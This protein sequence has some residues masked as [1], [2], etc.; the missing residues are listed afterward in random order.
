MFLLYAEKNKITIKEKEIVT[1]G[2]ANIYDVQF[3]FDDDWEGLERVAVFRVGSTSVSIALTEENQ[4]LLPWECMQR[5]D[6]GK[7]IS[8]GVYGQFGDDVVLPTVWATLGVIKRS[9][10]L[11]DDALPKTPTL[12]EQLLAQIVSEREAA[13]QAAESAAKEA[14]KEV[15]KETEGLIEEHV[16]GIVDAYLEENP[17]TGGTIN[18]IP[19]GGKAG[20]I[21]KKASDKDFDVEWG[22]FEIPE[23][24]GLITYDQDKTITIT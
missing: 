18:G 10:E 8:V 5:N 3:A 20:Q 4:C 11:G 16:P 23:Q 9:V 15:A 1:A 12:A 2:S 19:A 24:Y 21:L 13:E 7:M 14:V 6:V 17:P 22:D